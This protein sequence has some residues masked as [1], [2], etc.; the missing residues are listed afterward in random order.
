MGVDLPNADEMASGRLQIFKRYK[1][2]NLR[3]KISFFTQWGQNLMVSGSDLLFGNW[4]IKRGV[5]MTPHHEGEQLVWQAHV[6]V[7]E[8][9]ELE[10]KFCLV[11]EKLNVL[12]WEAGPSR[13]LQLP[14]NLPD[15]AVVDILDYWQEGAS[16]EALLSRT[17]FKKVIFGEGDDEGASKKIQQTRLP[18]PP[19]EAFTTKDSVVVRFRTICSRL[20]KGQKVFLVGNSTALGMWN[21]ETAYQLTNTHDSV[22]EADVVLNRYAL[23]DNDGNVTTEHGDDIELGLDS[24]ARKPSI[25]II[26]SDGYFRTVSWKGAGLA[27]PVF[28]I[29]SKESVGA[30]EFLDLKSLVDL[31]AQAG[32]RLVQLLPVNDTSVHGMWWDSYPYSSLSV[33]ALHPLYLRLQAL[34]KSIPEDIQ[35]KIDTCRAKLNEEPA[36]DYDGTM[37]AKLSIAK[38][39]FVL[40]KDDFLQSE[41][42]LSFFEE[43]KGWLKSYAAFCFLRD[44]FGTADHSQ[45]GAHSS[46]SE[47]KLDKLVAPTTDYYSAIAFWYYIQYHLFV[48][49]REAAQYARKNR[50]ILKG[51]LPIGVGRHSVDTWQYPTLFRMDTSTGAPPDMFDANGQNWGFPTYNWEEMAKDNYQWW[52]SRL[53][54]LEKFF[55]AYRIDHILGFFRIWELPDHAHTGILGHFR[56]SIPISAEEMEAEGLWDFDRLCHPYVRAH[57][58]EQTFR[59]RWEEVALKYFDEYHHLCYKFKEEFNTEKK[60]LAD[61]AK[62]GENSPDWLKE[63]TLALQKGLF[64]IMSDVCLIR[65]TQDPRKFYPRFGMDQTASFQDLDDHAKDVLRRLYQDYYFQRQETL[66]RETALKTLPVLMN[67]SEMLTCG[68]DLGLVP[69]CVQPVLNELG[70]LG[71]R[72]QRMPTGPGKEFNNPADYEYLTVC[73][74]SCHDTSTLRAWYEEDA[75]R[76]QSFFNTALGFNAAAPDKCTPEVVRAVIHQHCESPSVWAIFPLQDLMALDAKYAER[77]ANEETINDPTNPKHYWRFRGHVPVEDL[78]SNKPW[79]AGLQ[80]LLLTSGRTSPKDIG[81]ELSAVKQVSQTLANTSI[82]NSNY[83]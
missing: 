60:I 7:P 68:E 65:D 71:L 45:W 5:W 4:S 22:W 23:K 50:V 20:E 72:I 77:P 74:P 8:N 39:L 35:E 81:T 33:F 53:S 58:L 57:L 64:D 51:D 73:A 6:A 9:F 26:V 83:S 10:Y 66:W 27:T 48:Q 36:V 43:N 15:G 34:S 78:L 3:F 82:G 18:R 17:T 37:Q 30:G 2:I 1:R 16:P 80:E 75:Q 13:Q 46:F 29:R 62:G 76:R 59:K 31:S 44:F 54:Q 38:E 11:D 63:E 79:V 69:A 49:L 56:P 42:F 40:E 19:A 25:M 32:L 21:H 61:L 67:S 41:S 47:E 12:N 24:A 14:D 70:L 55:S 52:R 28:S